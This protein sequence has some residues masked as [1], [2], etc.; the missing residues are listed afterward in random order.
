MKLIGVKGRIIN[1]DKLGIFCC[2]W[3][4]G[5]TAVGFLLLCKRSVVAVYGICSRRTAG[6]CKKRIVD[7]ISEYRNCSV[8]H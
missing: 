6:C 5:I 8:I 2:L 4:Q 1:L 3:K 7:V